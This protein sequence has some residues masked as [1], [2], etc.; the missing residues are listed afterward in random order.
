MSEPFQ[1]HPKRLVEAFENAILFSSDAKGFETNDT[2]LV[3]FDGEHLVF[4]GRGKYSCCVHRLTPASEC[5]AEPWDVIVDIDSALDSV[6]ALKKVDGYGRKDTTVEVHS[7]ESGFFVSDGAEAVATLLEDEDSSAL[8][9]D[10]EFQGMYEVVDKAQALPA[11]PF[12]NDS[13][14]FT[15]GVLAKLAKVKL[16]SPLKDEN[17]WGAQYLG[18]ATFRFLMTDHDAN[19]EAYLEATREG[20]L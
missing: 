19:F 15:R 3:G 17:V 12:E 2:V 6:A 7:I 1:V 5:G 9:G 13:L 14:A 10:D 8:R 18:G 11:L 16:G 4:T 20:F